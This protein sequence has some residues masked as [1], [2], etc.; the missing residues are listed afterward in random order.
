MPGNYV[1]EGKALKRGL[2]ELGKTQRWLVERLKKKAGIAVCI[3]TMCRY[4]N[5]YPMPVRTW[6]EIRTHIFAYERERQR[7]IKQKKA[8]APSIDTRIREDNRNI[9]K[10]ESDFRREEIK[11]LLRQ[12]GR[13][14]RWL[15]ESIG[16][17]YN[18][19]KGWLSGKRTIPVEAHQAMVDAI[20]QRLIQNISDYRSGVIERNKNYR[21]N[22]A[23][24]VVYLDPWSYKKLEE[25]A[26]RNVVS[27]EEMA[28]RILNYSLNGHFI[29]GA[30]S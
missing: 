17:P 1:N 10:Q 23:P 30:W 20:T 4:C 12:C 18:T 9:R 3:N 6:E 24:L 21:E 5:D 7:R 2:K 22:N 8:E 19:V 26:N 11:K 13:K 27:V 29:P 15:A 14:T 16:R 25:E 28:Q